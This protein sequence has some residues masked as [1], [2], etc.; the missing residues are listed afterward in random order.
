MIYILRQ[1][2]SYL[3]PKVELVEAVTVE[4]AEIYIFYRFKEI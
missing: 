3:E 2:S 4:E 1:V